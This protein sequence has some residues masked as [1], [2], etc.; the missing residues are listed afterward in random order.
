MSGGIDSSNLVYSLKKDNV[1][2]ETFSIGFQDEKKNEAHF[3][4][5]ISSLLN[6]SHNEKF[7]NNSDCINVIPDIVKYYDEP[8][9]DPSQIPT[10]LLSKFAREKIKVAISG[11]GADELFGGYPRYQNIS[12]FWEIL[13]RFP[14]FLK[15]DERF[16]I[17]L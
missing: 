9:A 11:D 12:N 4:K 5:E 14:E 16:F 2:I 17:L 3:A 8:F 10:F 7:L 1:N 15:Q 6:I 13:H